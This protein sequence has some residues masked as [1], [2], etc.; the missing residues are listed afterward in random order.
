MVRVR[1]GLTR[2]KHR[3]GHGSTSFCFGSKNLGSGQVG[4]SQKILTR[5]AM[6]THQP[7]STQ[8]SLITSTELAFRLTEKASAVRTSDPILDTNR[9]TDQTNPNI[10][11]KITNSRNV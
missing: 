1:V 7:S 5:F 4:S 3:S 8:Q 11:N 10:Y 9:I 6:S 2:K